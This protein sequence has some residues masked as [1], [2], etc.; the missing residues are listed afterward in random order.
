M[1]KNDFWWQLALYSLGVCLFLFLPCFKYSE[2]TGWD[3]IEDYI[4]YWGS[5]SRRSYVKEYIVLFFL[6]FPA[7]LLGVFLSSWN[8]LIGS[9]ICTIAFIMP[10]GFI[11]CLEL[12]EQSSITYIFSLVSLI[13]AAGWSVLNIIQAFISIIEKSKE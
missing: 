7:A 2:A 9:I 8:R 11:L 10:L 5:I 12:D 13:I 1:K 3:K 4:E 6:S